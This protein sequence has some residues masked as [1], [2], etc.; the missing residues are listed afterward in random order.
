MVGVATAAMH[1]RSCL[2][3]RSVGCCLSFEKCEQKGIFHPHTSH[4]SIATFSGNQVR[5][6]I[7]FCHQDCCWCCR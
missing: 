6:V 1:G 2:L 5:L 4:F 3:H 7:V